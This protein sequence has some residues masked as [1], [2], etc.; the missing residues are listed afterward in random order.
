[1]I[2]EEDPR[3]KNLERKIGI[4]IALALAG[5]LV[6]FVLF[7]L[8]KD[9]FTKKYILSFTADRGT[10]FSKGMPVKLSG[11]RI[12]RVTAI[13]LNKQAMVDIFLE[14]D[15]DY[16]TWIRS[17]SI[18]KLVKEGL[19]GDMIIDISVG[20]PDKPQLKDR[21]TITY[22]KTKGLDELAE[23]IAQKVKPVLI[24]VRDIISYVNDPEGDLKKTIRNAEQLTRRLEETRQ[25]ADQFLVATTGNVNKVTVRATDL[26][27]TTRSRID[28]LDLAPTLARVNNTLELIDRK[29]PP[30]LEKTDAI[31]QNVNGISYET[32]QLAE[33]VFPKIPGVVSQAE[34]VMLSTDRLINSL[35]NTWL[36]R[37]SS[38][39][40]AGQG[41]IRGDSHE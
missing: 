34:D 22:I 32:R 18:A 2:R 39:P 19:I 16:R 40:A 25:H 1:M 5:I 26:L 30:M 9:F 35:Q 8:Q 6:A 23:E 41:F 12:G 11:F 31:L 10:G 38:A 29:V 21:D 7:G 13:S 4:F 3:F 14:I 28:A 37:D 20:S 27:D 17:D 36:L 15:A 24:E 33:K